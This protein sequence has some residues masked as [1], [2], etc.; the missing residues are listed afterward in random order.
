MRCVA[1]GCFIVLVGAAF[2]PSARAADA[3]G[4]PLVVLTSASRRDTD[5]VFA[6]YASGRVLSVAPGSN[7][8][9]HY[10]LATLTDSERRALLGGLPLAAVG[11]MHPPRRLGQDG[12]SECIRVF[13]HLGWATDVHWPRRNVVDR[14]RALVASGQSRTRGL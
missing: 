13:E 7:D 14:R 8:Y 3:W 5:L 2:A 6:L 4:Q 11:H 12:S 1:L 10:R 9:S